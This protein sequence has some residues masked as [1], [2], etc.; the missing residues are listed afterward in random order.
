MTSIGCPA[1]AGSQ[2]GCS[3]VVGC[4]EI[5]SLSSLSLYTQTAD[6]LPPCLLMSLPHMQE[7]AGDAAPLQGKLHCTRQA[8]AVGHVACHCHPQGH[9]PPGGCGRS[10]WWAPDRQRDRADT[11]KVGA[12]CCAGL[13]GRQREF[14]GIAVNQT[15]LW[16]LQ[17]Q[18]GPTWRCSPSKACVSFVLPPLLQAA[19]GGC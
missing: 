13:C 16:H 8:A 17:L 12:G 10:Q 9:R 1:V 19:A 5:D 3:C 7:D 18:A 6:D 11:G 2:Q 14:S 4:N 15:T